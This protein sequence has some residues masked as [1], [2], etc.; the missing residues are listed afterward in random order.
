MTNTSLDA[1][2][3][4]LL[5]DDTNTLDATLISPSELARVT[6]GGGRVPPIDPT[7]LG[8]A[9]GEGI[10]GTIEQWPHIRD[11]INYA[12]E[13]YNPVYWALDWGIKRIKDYFTPKKPG[14]LYWPSAPNPDGTVNT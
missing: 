6:G 5:T 3:R 8:Q 14:S 1:I 7:G 2:S 4:D 12:N 10:K 9:L 11:S 13:H